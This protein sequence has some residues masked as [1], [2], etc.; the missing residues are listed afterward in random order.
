MRKIPEARSDTVIELR[1]GVGFSEAFTGNYSLVGAIDITDYSLVNTST[2]E[3]LNTPWWSAYDNKA[4]Y[5]ERDANDGINGNQNIVF[6]EDDY[7]DTEKWWPAPLGK[8]SSTTT[9]G[10]VYPDSIVSGFVRNRLDNIPDTRLPL[11]SLSEDGPYDGNV[12]SFGEDP[13]GSG[14][15]QGSIGGA[16]PQ[17]PINNPLMRS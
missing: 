11:T 7:G 14:E 2:G 3:R 15:I 12:V 17:S 5:F 13:P 4:V 10:K 1:K 6:N 9:S 8:E 16:G